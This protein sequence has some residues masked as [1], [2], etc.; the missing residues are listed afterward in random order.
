MPCTPPLHIVAQR[1]TVAPLPGRSRGQPCT[2]LL[3]TVVRCP[4]VSLLP[5][6]SR[7]L[8]CRAL[9]TSVAESHPPPPLPDAALA[10]CSH[11]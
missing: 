9:A 10:L 3:H 8:P 1:Q 5:G 11:C 6:R 2:P 4:A 7:G